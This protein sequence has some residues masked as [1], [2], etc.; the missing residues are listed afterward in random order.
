MEM[1]V[2]IVGAGPSG[3]ATSVCLRQFSIPHLILEKEDCYAS[4]WKKRAYNRLK[5]HLAKEFCH[6]PFKPHSPSSPTY[7]SKDGFIQ[8]LDE[9]VATFNIQA[10]YHRCVE[11][12]VYDQVSQKWQIQAKNTLSG[13]LENYVAK[14]LVVATGENSEGYIPRLRGLDNFKGEIVHSS[15]YKS[16]S[17]YENMEVLVVGC[18]NSGM[19]IAYDLSNFGAR[20]SIVIRSPFHVLTKE[21]VRLAMSLQKYLPTSLVDF[22]IVWV[23]QF[24]YGDLSKY[25]LHRPTKGPFAIKETT[26]RSPVIDV[27]TI[28][29]IQEKEIKVFMEI[30]SINENNVEFKDGVEREF[31]AI[32]FATGYKSLTNNWLKDYSFLLND[33][34]MPRNKFPT[35]WKGQHGL[36]CAGFA[37]RGLFGVSMDAKAIAKDINNVMVNRNDY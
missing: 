2:L 25:G 29:R 4:L 3:L 28:K 10:R 34:G 6:L 16:G 33:E 15:K 12:A 8:Y 31:D 23:A 20:T 30:S 26:G 32:V 11:S 35:H 1:A 21:M 36:Y 7:I 9:Y 19:E 24:Y 37:R 13:S 17:E 14:F 22:I 27:G 18:G 5:L